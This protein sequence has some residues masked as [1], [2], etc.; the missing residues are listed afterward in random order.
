MTLA[1][2][3]DLP[4]RVCSRGELTG[5]GVPLDRRLDGDRIAVLIER[6]GPPEPNRNRFG[7]VASLVPA[8]LFA[9]ALWFLDR[10]PLGLTASASLQSGARLS[11]GLSRGRVLRERKL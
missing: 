4:L 5:K 3:C 2:P 9:R 8:L 10:A 1:S 11:L 7:T 6:D